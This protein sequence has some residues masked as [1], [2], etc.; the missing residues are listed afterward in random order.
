MP[1]HVPDPRGTTRREAHF[2]DRVVRCFVDRPSG[3]LAM[4]QQAA[5]RAPQREALVCGAR[6]LTWRKTLEG[7]LHIAGGLRA[8]GVARGDRIALL[9]GNEIEFP[10]LTFAAAALGAVIVPIGVREQA[11]GIAYILR[12]SGARLLVYDAA[13][14]GGRR[15]RGFALRSV[16]RRPAP[17]SRQ[18]GRCR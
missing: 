3:V 16:A 15:Q 10:L 11:A 2:G 6:R 8:K 13:G 12:H 9:L 17:G 18:P 5:D 7:A 4:L 1:D 14:R